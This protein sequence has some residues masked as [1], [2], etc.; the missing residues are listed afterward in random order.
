MSAPAELLA[1]L[2]RAA[3]SPRGIAV[4]HVG[5]GANAALNALYAAMRDPQAP[6]EP[7]L[8]FQRA[9]LGGAQ[10]EIWITHQ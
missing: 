3:D 6:R 4:A 9:P 7:A 1:L 2:H 10:D 8:K 5:I